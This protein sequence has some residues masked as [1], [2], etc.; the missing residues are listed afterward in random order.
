MSEQH[1]EIEA[2]LEQNELL[3]DALANIQIS[4]KSFTP[5]ALMHRKTSTG[6]LMGLKAC[7]M[8]ADKVLNKCSLIEGRIQNESASNIGG[9]GE[10]TSEQS[11]AESASISS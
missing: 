8:V 5:N 11:A 4:Y 6:I 2:M 7:A 9:T 10:G 3:K 1:S